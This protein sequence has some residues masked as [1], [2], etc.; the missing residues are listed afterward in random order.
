MNYYIYFGTVF[1][2]KT[3]LGDILRVSPKE[4]QLLFNNIYTFEILYMKI[5]A[6]YKHKTIIVFNTYNKYI[7]DRFISLS[8]RYSPV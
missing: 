8:K 6:V 1:D 4:F 3:D 7:M 2:L 5:K